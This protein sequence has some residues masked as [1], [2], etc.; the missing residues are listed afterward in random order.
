MLRTYKDLEKD[1]NLIKNI[2]INIRKVETYLNP[3]LVEP[4]YYDFDNIV[5]SIGDK[6]GVENMEIINWFV[7]ENEFGEQKR[8]F[9]GKNYNTIKDVFKFILDNK[10]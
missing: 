4:L 6:Y 9:N 1:I 5:D 3:N 10:S 8:L 7:F 2:Y